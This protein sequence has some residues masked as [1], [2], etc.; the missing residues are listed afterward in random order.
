MKHSREYEIAFVGLKPGEHEYHYLI[1]DNFFDKLL[2]N[3]DIDKPEFTQAQV[4]VKLQ[5]DKK[6][7]TMLLRF[8]I[9]GKVRI[10]CDRCG[11]EFDMT[12][13][14]EFELL[15]KIVEDDVVDKLSQDDAEV[16]YIGR[17]ESLL[18]LEN[19]LYEFITL[20]IPMQ[21]VHEDDEKGNSLCNPEVLKYLNQQK[22]PTEN[23]LLTELK[24]KKLT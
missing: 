20:S 22:P 13:W 8:D 6:P 12:L 19:W 1:Q 9:H 18:H 14:D 11:E 17:S 21:H 16:A 5:L 4:E 23:T 2:Q 15:V 24:K 10:P 7:G 3:G